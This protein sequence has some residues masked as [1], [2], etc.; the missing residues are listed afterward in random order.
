MQQ[1][2]YFLSLA[3]TLN[4][5]RAAEQCNV[6]QP[7]LT[8]AIKGLEEEL[9]GELIRREGRLSHLTELGQR[10]L[11][12][13]Q[14]CYEGAASAKALARSVAAGDTASLAVGVSRTINVELLMGCL[15]ELYG[16]FP[17]LQL[18]IR[19]G[20]A[21]QIIEMLKSGEVEL[22]V[23]GPLDGAWERLDAWPLFSEEFELVVGADHP[24]AGRN[25]DRIDGDML[26]GERFLIQVGSEMAEQQIARLNAGGV[27]T[28]NAHEVETDRDMTAL[29][30]ANLGIALAPA[31]APK[32]AKLRRLRL[33]SL[34][35]RRSVSVY[36]AAGRRR[37]VEAGTLLNLLRA[38]DWR[39]RLG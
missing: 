38:T 10:M 39:A 27:P 37:P 5:T 23:A 35:L 2:R 22:A 25:E 11:P 31:S 34:D 14:Q 4:F 12:L 6:T 36:A 26:Q 13:L 18:K 9:G 29:L 15:T 24:L 33:S 7:A 16:A 3:S 8:R 21:S 17:S 1:V 28:S 30:E 19:R 32:S 20:S